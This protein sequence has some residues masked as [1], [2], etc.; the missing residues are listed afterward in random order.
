MMFITSPVSVIR[1]G[2]ML[3]LYMFISIISYERDKLDKELPPVVEDLVKERI[4]P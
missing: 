1:F 3:Y 4:A 2:A